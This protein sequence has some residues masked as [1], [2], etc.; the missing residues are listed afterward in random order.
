MRSRPSLLRAIG[1]AAL[2]LTLSFTA[3]AASHPAFDAIYVFGDSYSDV[4]NIFIA[5]NGTIPA[6]PYFNGRFSNGP[7]WIDHLAGTYGVTVK[8]S[9]AGGTDYA[10]GGA[11]VT[12]AVPVAGST[13]TI[14]SIP[15][16]V[17]L[18][19]S[20]HNFKADPKALY[21]VVGGGNDILN[22][23]GGSPDTLGGEIAFGLLS[24]I[25]QLQRAGARYFFVPHFFNI[26]LLPAAQGNA[27]FA[28]AATQA[29]NTD[30]DAGLF[31]ESFLPNTHFYRSDT[32]SLLQGVVADGSHYG[33][34]DITHPCLNTAV[35]PPTL[36]SNPYTNFFWDAEHPTIFGHSFLAVAAEQAIDR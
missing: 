12:Q 29:L 16:Q 10:F 33:F 5:S 32:Y 25:A 2:M 14:P 18:Y 1:I 35:N 23:T 11:E 36:C 31:I 28:L 3:Y 30:L 24:S 6:A 26:G 8:P 13:Q 15:E 19:L 17:A 20:Q 7:I 22:A 34:T 21:I 4:G 9:L 27:A